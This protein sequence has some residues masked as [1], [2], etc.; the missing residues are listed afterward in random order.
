MNKKTILII[1]VVLLVVIIGAVIAYFMIPKESKDNNKNEK[2]NSVSSSKSSNEEKDVSNNIE[3][4]EKEVSEYSIKNS[5][6][7]NIKGS[8]VKRMIDT[9]ILSNTQNA[10]VNGKF[11]S[12]EAGEITNYKNG[13]DL[14]NACK[15]ANTYE[16][17]KNTQDNISAAQEEMNTL[18]NKINSGKDYKVTA[19]YESE[20][21][22]KVK[23]EEIK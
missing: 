18:R 23:I 1:C 22:Y 21:I 15:K 7:D 14:A 8:E 6:G 9:I 19:E 2:N 10:N 16:G 5:I 4:T 13:A 3:N 20:V 17:G 11:I 12:I